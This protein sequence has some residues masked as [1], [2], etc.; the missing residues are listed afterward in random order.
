MD[1]PCHHPQHWLLNAGQLKNEWLTNG[2]INSKPVSYVNTFICMCRNSD[3]L[4][5]IL[6]ER[7]NMYSIV[8]EPTVKIQLC[9]NTNFNI[10]F[11]FIMLDAHFISIQFT[12]FIIQ[13]T[14]FTSIVILIIIIIE[15]SYIHISLEN[16]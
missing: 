12:S 11:S 3:S 9:F 2:Y 8:N 15:C 1:Y 5:C 14:S 16:F 6:G 13:F 7:T 4:P 10:M